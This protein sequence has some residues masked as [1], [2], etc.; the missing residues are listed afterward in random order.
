M[1]FKYNFFENLEDF[2]KHEKNIDVN[3]RISINN[4]C[5]SVKDISGI[6]LA[7]IN[8]CKEFVDLF[9]LLFGQ[10][11][12]QSN[13]P[14]SKQYPSF[15]NYWLKHKL[16][17]APVSAEHRKFFYEKIE[18][19]Y[20]NFNAE[21]IL[22]DNINDFNDKYYY[23]MHSLY[24][25]YEQFFK[26]KENS[27]KN[28][29]NF[30][31]NIKEKYKKAWNKCFEEPDTT[32]CN[33]LNR[34]ISLHESHKTLLSGRCAETQLTP[35]PEFLLKSSTKDMY[36]KNITKGNQ[37]IQ[38]SSYYS[39]FGLTSLNGEKYTNLKDLVALH[40]HTVLYYNKKDK[41]DTMMKILNEFLQ[42]YIDNNKNNDVLP[43]ITE[44]FEDY[45][46]TK[47]TEYEHIYT[48]CSTMDDPTKDYCNLYKKCKEQL[49]T[50]LSLKE[51]ELQKT[52]EDN[53]KSNQSSGTEF[54]SIEYLSSVFKSIGNIS[55]IIPTSIGA[56]L[57]LSL[58]SF[59][60]YK[61][62]KNYI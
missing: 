20:K 34:F 36:P 42:Y 11:A 15:L 14:I 9:T 37:L 1:F 16:N 35:I 13:T 3:S 43:F 41:Y 54:L 26:L 10:Y 62:Y 32:F 5:D 30:L 4:F 52:I 31:T 59:F 39:T 56:L 17:A 2:I 27:S 55:S 51:V 47:K 60:S 61:V 25:L 12:A 22:N 8:I 38:K 21:Q 6:N 19:N 33:A 45:Y 53:I 24:E 49:N 23:K 29:L 18:Q 7:A 44:F 48:E 40:Y 57:I 58:I 28:C 50:D 46:N